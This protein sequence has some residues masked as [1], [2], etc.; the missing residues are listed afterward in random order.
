MPLH[1]ILI[2]LKKRR[3]VVV[4]SDAKADNWS[5]R[6][7]MRLV[8]FRHIPMIM[9][10]PSSVTKRAITALTP[11]PICS[12]VLADRYASSG[13]SDAS[14]VHLRVARALA[15]AE[16]PTH[17]EKVFR[18]F[19][20]NMRW[21]AIGAG[22]IMA[23]AGTSE[24]TTMVNCFVHP[25]GLGDQ[26]LSFDNGLAQACTTL[27]M[28]GGVGYDFSP[29]PPA[30]AHADERSTLPS[31]C[32]AIDRY[33]QASLG[34][35]FKG[36]RR[37]AQMAVLACTHPDLLEFVQA[38]RCR[39]RWLTFNVSVAVTDNFLRAVLDDLPWPLIHTAKPD[40]RSIA[41]GAHQLADGNW[42]YGL[43]SARELWGVI[44]EEALISS[45]P[46]LLY[47]DKINHTNNLRSIETITA[48]N[49]C[50]EQPLPSYGSCVLGPINLT[51]LVVNPFGSTGAP[52]IDWQRLAT[53]TRTQVRLLDNVIELTNWPISSQAAEAFAK[54][55]IGVGV[56]GLSDMLIMLGLRYDDDSGR[57]MAGQV[58]RFIRDHAYAAS[59][60]L[61][62]ERGPFPSYREHD[63]LAEGTIGDTLPLFVRDA[64]KKHGLRNSHL[65]SIAPTGSVSL[66]F[67]DNCSNGVEPAYDWSYSRT[68]HFRGSPSMEMTVENH[69]WRLWRHLH[70]ENA[71]LP[72]YFVNAASVSPND[73][74]AMLAAIQPYVDASVSKTVPI[75]TDCSKEYVQALFMRAWHLGLKG[76]TVFRPDPRMD[77]VMRTIG[78]RT[79][80][81]ESRECGV[82]V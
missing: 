31:V 81:P 47:I 39:R 19:L 15:Q 41:Q 26:S 14:D 54:R 68:V 71:R 21:G 20:Q 22:R 82:C 27:T 37:G 44:T 18:R 50:G 23:N 69:A 57:S 4:H 70:G 28:G 67:A 60:A 61:A 33:N 58:V 13:E 53:M 56:T 76:L 48:T 55:R 45:E 49:P 64:I 32:A 29:L 36:S 11:Q 75:A 8:R 24:N 17:R 62:A 73:H 10:K 30:S 5:V 65:L 40:A 25:I 35:P 6:S 7:K 46:G 34:L 79:S 43:E 72:D 52:S 80:G 66:A 1:D 38:K 2:Y 12:R 42:Q 63:Y 51:R 3:A 74:V 9:P 78:A 59:A 16:R 77:A